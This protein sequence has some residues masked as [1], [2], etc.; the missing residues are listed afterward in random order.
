MKTYQRI[1]QLLMAMDNCQAMDNKEWFGRHAQ[2]LDELV[3]NN[4][5]SG[6]GFFRTKFDRESS[7]PN[8]LVFIMNCHHQTYEE[9]TWL[10]LDTWFKITVTVVPDLFSRFSLVIKGVE[11]DDADEKEDVMDYIN[12]IFSEFLE[13]ETK[14]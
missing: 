3:E 11:C 1:A 2:A 6:R 10:Q 12:E 5:P 4:A 9:P 7:N 14:P 8:K 13:T